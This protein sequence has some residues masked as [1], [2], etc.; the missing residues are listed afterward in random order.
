M[1]FWWV[2]QNQTYRHEVAGGYLWSPKR[3][4]NG[5]T[6]PFYEFMREVAPGD[7]IFSFC[8]TY[9]KAIGVARSHGYEAPKP[10]EFGSVGAYWEQ[11]GWRVDVVFRELT[12]AIRPADHMDVLAPLL[13]AKYAPLQPSG[14]GLQGV[15]LTFISN[16]LGFALADLIG[17]EAHAL[18]RR[19]EIRE[20]DEPVEAVG[21][22][23][24]EKHQIEVVVS[25]TS[26]EETTRSAIVQARKGQGLFR[27]RVMAIERACR[28]TGVERPEHLRASHCKPWRDASNDERLSAE[29]G[30]LLTPDA[31]HLFD[32]GF[33]AFD[34]GGELLVSPV[35]HIDSMKRMGIDPDAIR[36]VGRFSEGQRH[37][38]KFHR[39]NVFLKARL[40]GR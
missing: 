9:I 40:A 38:L 2:N 17:A 10:I 27:Q 12:H 28:L 37:F 19:T 3:N 39:E 14:R 20:L 7:L 6:N 21:L 8:D 32:R 15:Y 31:D 36:N 1:R 22:V 29:N 13:P 35:A 34:D 30:L 24:W 5:A 25:D 11:I 26:I 23:E 33:I 18:V 16:Y 4:A